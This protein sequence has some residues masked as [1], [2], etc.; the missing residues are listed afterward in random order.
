VKPCVRAQGLAAGAEPVLR[1]W[2]RGLTMV[3]LTSGCGYPVCTYAV[4]ANNLQSLLTGQPRRRGSEFRRPDSLDRLLSPRQLPQPDWLRA[5]N[6]SCKHL[7]Q[8][9][10]INSI[11]NIPVCRHAALA[12]SSSRRLLVA[13]THAVYPLYF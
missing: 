10:I 1:R 5:L 4:V 11:P 7:P 9:F 8:C 2:D 6:D 13:S 12:L 3:N